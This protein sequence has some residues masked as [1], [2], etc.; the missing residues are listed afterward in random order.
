MLRECENN[1]TSTP[2]KKIGSR[3]S[4]NKNYG[5]DSAVPFD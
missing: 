4:E 5:D 3:K 1:K 2:F